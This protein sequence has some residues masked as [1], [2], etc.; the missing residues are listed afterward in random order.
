MNNIEQ[1]AGVL[2]V[3]LD[4]IDVSQHHLF[5][6]GEVLPLFARLRRE[7]PVHYCADSQYG[8]YWSVTK[9]EDVYKRQGRR[10]SIGRAASPARCAT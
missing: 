2:G 4:R 6:T 5:R 1:D 9:L 7:D 8:P 10:Q 3:P